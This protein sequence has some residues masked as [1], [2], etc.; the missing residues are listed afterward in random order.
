MFVGEAEP[1]ITRRNHLSMFEF[2]LRLHPWANTVKPTEFVGVGMV[3]LVKGGEH[4][5]DVEN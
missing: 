5:V 1:S 2:V 4:R 3:N